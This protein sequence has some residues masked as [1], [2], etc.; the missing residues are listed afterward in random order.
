VRILALETTEKSATVAALED[1]R[2][3]GAAQLDPTRRSA[4]T[5]AGG[6]KRLLADVGWRPADVQLVAVAVGPGSFTGLRVGVTTAKTLAYA[7]G[8]EVMGVNTLEVIAAQTPADAAAVW[9]VLDAQRNQVY[10]A[11][12]VRTQEGLRTDRATEIRDVDAWLAMLTP[13]DV[14]SGPV[15]GKLAGRLPPGVVAVAAELW[16][17]A[18]E[19]VGRL[20]L[21]HYEAGERDDLW[22]LV[23]HYYR[24]SAAEEKYDERR[25]AAGSSST[26]PEP[27]PPG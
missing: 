2:L 19:Q 27:A 16:S 13:G 11:R 6:M 26:G 4:Q 10:A 5:L 8:A 14:V 20:A 17:P 15:L 9:A 22:R 23:P 1:R 25:H 18:A 21:V 7:V 3:L 24:K 12:F